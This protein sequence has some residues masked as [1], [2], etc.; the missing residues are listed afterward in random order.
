MLELEEKKITFLISSLEGG[1]AEGVCVNLANSLVERGW[2]V[3]LIVMHMENA[4]FKNLLSEKIIVDVLNVPHARNSIIPL[5]KKLIKLKPRKILVFNYEFTIIVLL[6]K[7]MLRLDIKVIARNI[8]NFSSKMTSIK[9]LSRGGILIALMRRMYSKVDHVIN[10][11]HGM[12]E[13]LL[14]VFPDFEGRT[15]VIYNPVN[16]EVY[17]AS[18]ESDNTKSSDSNYLLCVGRLEFQKRFEDAIEAFSLIAENYPNLRLKIAGK[19]S[20]EKDLIQFSEKCGV[21]K[22]VDFE[23]FQRDLIPHY[24]QAAALL[25][26]SRYEGF[27]NVLVEAI[28]M[29]LPIIS[30]DCPS[31]PN[32]IVVEGI[33]GY[34]VE[35]GNVN[36]LAQSIMHLLDEGVS[37]KC[38][39]N[40]SK[41]FR[42]E[43]I[44]SAYEAVL[45]Q[46]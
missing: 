12:N 45:D 11:C 5:A 7:G 32:E 29:G 9:R 14:K 10:Q 36:K 31:G 39:V 21:C 28:T 38:V 43:K 35:S 4:V 26:T 17:Q 3:R 13:D 18:L 30:Y 8:N 33:N 40:T 44:T 46:F 6:I 34:L 15:S 24:R 37:T 2:S 25:L 27:P 16:R 41:K 19:G 20:L 22:R 1:G 23:G 42:P